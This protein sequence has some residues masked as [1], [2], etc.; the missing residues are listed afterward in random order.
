MS[1]LL[2]QPVVIDNRGGAG[3]V[4]GTDAVAKAE[5]DGYTI[6]ITSAGALAISVS[7]QEKMPYD[8]PKDLQPDHAGRQGAGTA[9]GRDR[10]SGVSMKELVALAQGQAGQLNFALDRPG[11][12]AASRRRI[13]Q[14]AADRHRARAL[15]AR[16]RR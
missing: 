15:R 3:G 2:G 9:G 10:C 16:R 7:L 5:P 6:A 8:A 14:G 13:V 1:E 12:D 4:L 11:L